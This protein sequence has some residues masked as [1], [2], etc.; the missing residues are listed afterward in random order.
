[1]IKKIGGILGAA[2]LLAGII[3]SYHA[4]DSYVAKAEDI[5]QLRSSIQK[6]NERMDRK[7][8]LDRA[9]ELQRRIWDLERHYAGK[10]IPAMVQA[11]IDCLK[12][13][14]QELLTKWAR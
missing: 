10:P 4:F 7:A 1:M 5:K 12:T 8:D 2:V 6:L 14:R 13:E 11:E 3:G 9:R